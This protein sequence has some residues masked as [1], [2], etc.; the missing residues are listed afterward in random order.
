[1]ILLP[2]FSNFYRPYLF[3]NYLADRDFSKKLDLNQKII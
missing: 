3:K 1:M 2:P